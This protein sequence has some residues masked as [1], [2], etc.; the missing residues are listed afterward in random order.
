MTKF[1]EN[2][3]ELLEKGLS[4]SEIAKALN[5][6]INSVTSVLTRF[7][8]DISKRNYKYKHCKENYFDIIDNDVK[9]YLLGFFIADGNIDHKYS[10]MGISIQSIDK[11]VLEVF[12]KELDIP[13]E[14]VISNRHPEARKEQAQLRWSSPH[15]VKTLAKYNILPRKTYDTEFVFPFELIDSKFYGAF[16]RG[17]I[18]G[19]GSFENNGKGTFTFRLVST[20]ILFLKQIGGILENTIKDTKCCYRESKGKTVDWYTL[21]LSTL[22]KNKPEKILQF[23]KFLY[24]GSE[25]CFKRKRNKIETYLKYLGKLEN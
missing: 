18:D 12:K 6:P 20:S 14:I 8:I 16:L 2:A 1:Q 23:Y 9:A 13:N 11:S 5:R 3:L 10:R 19:D 4:P 22:G 25:F 15:M 7:N 24:D 21:R 17:L